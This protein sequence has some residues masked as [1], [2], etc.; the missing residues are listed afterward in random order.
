MNIIKTHY[1]R[2]TLFALVIVLSG[3]LII[4]RFI[5]QDQDKSSDKADKFKIGDSS[6]GKQVKGTVT[7]ETCSTNTCSNPSCSTNTCS[8]P[9]CTTNTCSSAGCYVDTCGGYI[10]PCTPEILGY[11]NT[12]GY[13]ACSA[14][15]TCSANICNGANTCSSDTCNGANTCSAGTCAWICE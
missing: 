3:S 8:N 13:D 5:K 4:G 2:L 15:D 1:K 10:G 7:Y 9:S 6:F 14:G 11:T 12:C